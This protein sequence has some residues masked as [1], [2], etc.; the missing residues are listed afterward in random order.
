MVDI[1]TI[2]EIGESVVSEIGLAGA[3]DGDVVRGHGTVVPEWCVPGTDV[4]RT[5]ILVVWADVVTGSVAGRAI[6]SRIPLTLDL[7]VHVIEPARVGDRLVI[8]ARQLKAGRTVAV[9]E[10]RLFHDGSKAPVAYAI[11]TF[12]A[13]PNPDHVFPDGAF[14]DLSDMPEGR[15]PEPVAERARITVPE[16]GVAEVP[17]R[18]ANPNAIQGGIVSLC[19]EE[20]VASLHDVPVVVDTMNLR[21]L[22]GITTGSGRAIAEPMG[23]STVVRVIDV[24]RDKLATIITARARPI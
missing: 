10:A 9:A 7:E 22:K 14:P 23:A 13:S 5:S 4:A 2:G 11:A 16:P 15:L 19:A 3:W 24:G 20:A 12:F 21:Y 18:G 17:H 6:T 1:P 8:E